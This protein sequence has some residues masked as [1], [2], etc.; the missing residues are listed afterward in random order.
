MTAAQGMLNATRALAA[1]CFMAALGGIGQLALA[2]DSTAT[3]EALKKELSPIVGGRNKLELQKAME[4][5][6]R[7]DYA[8][9][10]RIA[11][12]LAEAGDQYAQFALGMMYEQGEG[13]PQ[14]RAE[15]IKWYQKAA[16]QGHPSAQSD[17]AYLYEHGE[18]VPQDLAK[19]VVFYKAAAERGL[20][21]AQ[22]N[23]GTLYS[24]G[25]GVPKDNN[26]A[27]KWLRLA[28]KQGEGVAQ[29]N[30]GHM[31]AS[32][33][34]VTKDYYRAY[35]WF[36]LATVSD[37]LVTDELKGKA[38]ALRSVVTKRLSQQ[39]IAQA[40]QLVNDCLQRHYSGCD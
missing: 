35:V 36:K 38:N 18:G 25:K 28:A 27:V 21:E 24:K 39:Q 14:N 31:Y 19:A 2:M 29:I 15:A 11:R 33:L 3:Y 40:E 26:E 37:V 23:L 4:A 1:I 7:G 10:L 16:D 9:E 17:L 20:A 8:T 5:S 6:L 30:L 12:P 22:Y 34:G 13:V 32:G